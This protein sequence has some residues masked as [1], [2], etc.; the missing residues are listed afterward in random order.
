MYIPTV[1]ELM[2][3]FK[4][5]LT[6]RHPKI[7]NFSDGSMLSI[8]SEIINI[9]INLMYQRIDAET[10]SISILTAE[11]DDLDDLV[12]DRLPNGRQEGEHAT[13]NLTFS[14]IETATSAIPIPLGSKVMALG[15]DGSK[16]YFETTAYG[17]IAI[18][19]NSVIITA[20]SIEPSEDANVPAFAI[21]HIPYGIDGVDR[22]ENID[23]FSGGTDQESDDDLRTRYYYAVLATGTATSI[24]TEE[25][26]TDLDDINEAHIFSR[27]N[28]DIELVVDYSGGI[29]NDYDDIETVLEDNLAAG[30]ISR[31]KLIGTII[32]GVSTPGIGEAYGGR[33]YA[34][35]TTHCIAG[36]SFY[37]T[38]E[39]SLGRIRTSG[40]IMIP[41]NTIIGDI[42]TIPMEDDTDRATTTTEIFYSGSGSYDILTGMG[43][44]PYLY[45]L[46]R[47]VSINV[48]V[49]VNKTA[50]A[51][52][53]LDDDI[54]DS[55]TDF[56]N[57]FTIG[58]DLEW[59]DLFLNIYMDYSTQILFPGIDNI[60][61]C[62]IT[63][64][65]TTISIPGS[66]I[67]I[68]EDERIE[69]GEITV[70]VV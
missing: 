47:P 43:T 39:D 36:E 50:I 67:D 66:I 13:G 68:D 49:T 52:A 1:D 18:G 16:I 54:E 19:D 5:E 44:Y 12:V 17:E 24:V 70:T 27:G 20:R 35:A 64:D 29:G 38:Y 26:L 9:Q 32:D 33:L 57:S 55:I 3:S 4:E 59:S 7:R 45:N 60:S 61:S 10:K 56:L 58:T 65:G 51:S 14:C 46:P 62:V 2:D 41:A 40:T 34:R 11:G 6:S 63:G 22:V 69:A 21:T 48:N 28:G 53:T 8:L 42:I 23:E 25:H 37:L 30:I 31:G 15:T